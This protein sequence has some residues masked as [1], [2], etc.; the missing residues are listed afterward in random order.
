MSESARGEG[1]GC[2][3]HAGRTTRGR[4][5]GEIPEAE[6]DYFLGKNAIEASGTWC[7]RDI[8]T[9]EILLH[10]DCRGAERPKNSTTAVADG[11]G[12]LDHKLG[13]ILS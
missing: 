2:G 3:C 1:A 8:P 10:S 9:R 13:G 4:R 11:S 12:G 7:L 6:R 5:S